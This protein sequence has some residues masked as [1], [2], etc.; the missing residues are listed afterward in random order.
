MGREKGRPRLSQKSQTHFLLGS[1]TCPSCGQAAPADKLLWG[2]WQM[3]KSAALSSRTRARCVY[4]QKH[5]FTDFGGYC[6][7]D[8]H[9]S[10]CLTCKTVKLFLSLSFAMIIS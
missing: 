2:G 9:L 8:K 7:M 10:W 4:G 1:A 6:R 3:G 5:C